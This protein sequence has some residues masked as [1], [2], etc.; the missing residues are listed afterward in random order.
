M[1]KSLLFTGAIVAAVVLSGVKVYAD[2]A[3]DIESFYAVNQTVQYDNGGGSY[4][5]ITAVASTVGPAGGHN[6]TAYALLAQDST[7]SLDLYC[8]SAEFAIV[9]LGG[10]GTSGGLTPALGDN[11]TAVGQWNPY[12]QIPEFTFSTNAT[13]AG[14]SDTS[15]SANNLTLVSRLNPLPTTQITTVSAADQATLGVGLEGY[16]VELVNATISGGGA[17]SA[18][19]PNYAGGNATYSIT[20]STGSMTLYDW[21]TSYSTDAAMGGNAVPSGAVNVYGFVSVY[22]YGA[23]ASP[24]FLPISIV[25]EPSTV[26]LVGLG[27]V[28]LLGIRR[29]RS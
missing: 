22:G 7:G 27:L 14:T 9:G 16:Y 21:V 12:H 1:R 4:P 29:R 2:S 18:I 15:F 11:V 25:P 10:Y 28:G 17:H 13:E 26:M 6:F 5:V 3:S 24:E 19:F 8:Y 20:D 23:T